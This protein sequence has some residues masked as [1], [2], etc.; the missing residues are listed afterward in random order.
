MITDKVVL[1]VSHH[2]IGRTVFDHA[3]DNLQSLPYFLSAV[4]KV[5]RKYRLAL[6]VTV[7]AGR[8]G[9]PQFQ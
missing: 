8:F 5:A 7:K 6:R 2:R 1:M 4:Y 3:S 9:I